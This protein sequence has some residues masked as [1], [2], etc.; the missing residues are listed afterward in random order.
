LYHKCRLVHGDLSEYN[1]LVHKVALGGVGEGG[2]WC[3]I[4]RETNQGG[5]GEMGRGGE[6]CI[7]TAGWCTLT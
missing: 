5:R 1:L 3:R 7:R 4:K 2:G 6:G